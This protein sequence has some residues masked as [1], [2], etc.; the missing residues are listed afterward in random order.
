MDRQYRY[1][2]RRRAKDAE[3]AL[4]KMQQVQTRVFV[5]PEPEGIILQ[6][7]TNADPDSPLISLLEGILSHGIPTE[8]YVDPMLCEE[9][10]QGDGL[11]R[12]RGA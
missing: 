8:D 11:S 6:V 1:Y 7:R 2:G 12:F 10:Y 3:I 9:F 5:M 4:S